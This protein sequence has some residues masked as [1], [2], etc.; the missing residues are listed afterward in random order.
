MCV[1]LQSESEDLEQCNRL[2]GRLQSA[3]GRWGREWG[4]VALA[5]AQRLEVSLAAFADDMVGHVQVRVPA[6]VIFDD[7]AC[8]R[9]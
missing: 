3:E 7:A 8:G 1:R 5:A 4:L 2:W 6:T 9:F